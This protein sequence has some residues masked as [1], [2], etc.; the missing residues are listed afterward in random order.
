MSMTFDNQPENLAGRILDTLAGAAG[1]AI[2]GI[3][4][5]VEINRNRQLL[6]E[7]P[8]DILKDIGISRSDIDYVTAEPGRDTRGRYWNSPSP[9]G[10]GL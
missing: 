6:R 8:D 3:R 5:R 4:R 10:R 9:R 7:L 2:H 1:R